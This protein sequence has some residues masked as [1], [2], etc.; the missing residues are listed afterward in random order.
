MFVTFSSLY[1][2]EEVHVSRFNI[3]H[4]DKIAHFTF[5]FIACILGTLFLRERSLG[6]IPLTKAILLMILGTTCFGIL[7]EILQYSLTV[8]RMGDVLDGIVNTIGSICGGL[9]TK[10]YFSGKRRLKWRF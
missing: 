8:D 2:F 5:Y 1:S 7:M 6:Q 10:F 3:P 4:A 9:L